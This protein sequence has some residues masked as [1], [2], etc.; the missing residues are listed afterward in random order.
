MGAP[1]D[2]FE[3]E[4]IYSCW[5]LSTVHLSKATAEAWCASVP[6]NVDGVKYGYIVWSGSLQEPDA[7]YNWEG[8]PPEV[9]RARALARARKCRYI[10]YDQDGPVVEALADHVYIW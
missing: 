7:A 2:E 5:V 9:E 4:E 6:H 3:P 8:F 1:I 10:R